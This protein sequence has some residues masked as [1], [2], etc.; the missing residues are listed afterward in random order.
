M[1]LPSRFRSVFAILLPALA[2]A[3][4]DGIP[5]LSS[6][7][8]TLEEVGVVREAAPEGRTPLLQLPVYLRAAG[9]RGLW[10]LDTGS[11]RAVL[12]DPAAGPVATVSRPGHGPGEVWVPLGFDVAG[13]DEVWIAD[14][15]NAKIAGFRG[16]RV[17]REFVLDH[18]PLG[19]VATPD[20]TLWVGGDLMSSVLVRYDREG[21]RI[22]TAGVP[23]RPGA[24]WFRLNQGVLARGSGAC[25]VVWAYTFHSALECFAADGR[26]VWKVAG[27]VRV[28]PRRDADPFRM[29][30][31]DR[32]AYVD[33]TAAGG[34]VY[35]LFVG[36][37]AGDEGLRTDQVHVFDERTGTFAGRITLPR[38]AKFILRTDSTLAALDY[39]PEPLVRLYR[40]SGGD[41]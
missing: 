20:G 27:P 25:A 23:I 31:D 37:T 18:Q 38:P 34:R 32:F 16:G 30:P 40:M 17:L 19:I 22:G 6:A 5:D 35:A 28:E 33:V 24:R 41:S 9:A 7:G 2:A 10:T 13:P 36:R 15:G 12:L 1:L 3:C 11:K 21:R 39:D 8:L 26:S 29:S 4:G 14:P